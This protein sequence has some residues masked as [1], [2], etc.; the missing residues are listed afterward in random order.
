MFVAVP[1]NT[2]SGNRGFGGAGSGR[3]HSEPS[4]RCGCGA[5]ETGER[6]RPERRRQPRCEVIRR[7]RASAPPRPPL[8][9]RS[10]R[11]PPSPAG[12]PS[13]EPRRVLSRA[14]PLPGYRGGCRVGG[15]AGRAGALILLSRSPGRRPSR[16]PCTI[17]PP[18]PP[19][20]LHA[21]P[22]T[23]VPVPSRVFARRT[24]I[25]YHYAH[26]ARRTR[27]Q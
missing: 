2:F 18:P 4:P 19:R 27:Q 5:A 6:T 12:R 7:G 1:R 14:P 13:I 22:S 17:T 10:D 3:T 8:R 23:N 16:P 26:A 11:P 15:A 9:P 21:T 25:L 20:S 24:Y